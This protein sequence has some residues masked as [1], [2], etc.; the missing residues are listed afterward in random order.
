MIKLELPQE[1]LINL[2]STT[3]HHRRPYLEYLH[4]S[5]VKIF[6]FGWYIFENYFMSRE[7]YIKDSL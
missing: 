5:Q 2:A 1:T 6:Y 4:V 7:L 3:S